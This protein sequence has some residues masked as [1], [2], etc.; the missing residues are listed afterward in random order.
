MGN[1]VRQHPI[2][3]GLSRLVTPEPN[4]VET[5][6]QEIAAGWAIKNSPPQKTIK[7]MNKKQGNNKQ[8]LF[9]KENT[10]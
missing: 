1:R 2:P 9:G 10:P 5:G 7:D 8:L 3:P 4:A 6:K